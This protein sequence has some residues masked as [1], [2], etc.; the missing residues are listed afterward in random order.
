MKSE[1]PS[2]SEFA[3]FYDGGLSTSEHL[4]WAKHFRSCTDCQARSSEAGKPIPKA[5]NFP[6]V[7]PPPLPPAPKPDAKTETAPALEKIGPYFIRRLIGRGGM[8]AVYEALHDK[9]GRFVALKVLPRLAAID[10]E[11]L[12]R[13]EREIRAV[14]KLDHPNVVLATDAG[15]EQ[16]V[17][18]LAMELL[19]GIDLAHLIQQQGTLP[20][21]ESC[22]IGAQAARGLAHAH[23]RGIVHRDVKPSNLWITSEGVVKV[24]DLGLAMFVS[25]RTDER[26]TGPNM[27]GTTDYMAPEQWTNAAA[28]TDRADVY[29]LGC[30]LYQC[31]AGSPPFSGIDYDTH[32]SKKRGHLGDDPPSLL[33]KRGDVPDAVALLIEKMLSKETVDRPSANAVADELTPYIGRGSNLRGLVERTRLS[34]GQGFIDGPPTLPNPNLGQTLPYSPKSIGTAELESKPKRDRAG[35]IGIAALAFAAAILVVLLTRSFLNR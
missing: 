29:G 5:R 9:L 20:I 16:G 18:Y 28:A 23:Q 8:G 17:P 32:Y 19:D 27:L 31:F 21:A 7:I 25:A 33:D 2:P 3:A 4:R 10:P 11:Y 24:L 14:G 35:W 22:E 12:K 13:F 15:D 34:Q 26:I 30:A 1:C 6:E